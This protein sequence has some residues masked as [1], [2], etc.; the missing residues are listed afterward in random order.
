[1]QKVIVIAFVAVVLF[2]FM[3]VVS[4]VIILDHSMCKDIDKEVNPINQ[5][6]IFNTSDMKAVSWVKIKPISAKDTRWR[7]GISSAFG[8]GREVPIGGYGFG[9]PLRLRWEW[10]LPN[11]SIYSSSHSLLNCK[12][13]VREGGPHSCAY[14]LYIANKPP[15][16][17]PGDWHVDFYY[18]D[19]KKFTETF[20]IFAPTPE[21]TP[22]VTPTSTPS[23]TP[24]PEEGVPGFEAV[25][26]IVG[27]LP[28]A[29]LLRRRK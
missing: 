19:E 12:C 6:T 8:G 29:Y 17:I 11:G 26:A 4:A 27:L 20:T 22:T 2:M 13:I 7:D 21:P 3:G 5:T 9:D 16:N 28:V 1:M 23:S 24:T 14:F 10:Y 25:L 15:A 18:N